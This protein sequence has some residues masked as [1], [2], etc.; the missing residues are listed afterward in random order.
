MSPPT[1][2]P[3]TTART[4]RRILRE[5][6]RQQEREIDAQPFAFRGFGEVHRDQRSHGQAKTPVQVTQDGIHAHRQ[7]DHLRDCLR[8]VRD[9]AD[10]ATECCGQ[11][12]HRAEHQDQRHLH[13]ERQQHPEPAVEGI[14][15]GEQAIAQRKGRACQCKQHDD[16]GR[17]GVRHVVACPAGKSRDPLPHGRSP[18]ACSC[19]RMVDGCGHEGAF[20]YASPQAGG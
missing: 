18:P 4:A 19:T 17:S 15:V 8:Q 3:S 10:R 7:R 13:A 20:R 5:H 12:Q 16:S 11:A 1:A 14:D 9:A 2:R 6:R